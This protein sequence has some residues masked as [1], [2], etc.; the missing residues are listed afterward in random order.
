MRRWVVSFSFLNNCIRV[1][2]TSSMAVV[3]YSSKSD[4]EKFINMTLG[5]WSQSVAYLEMF[6]QSVRNGAAPLQIPSDDIL[7][8]KIFCNLVGDSIVPSR[9]STLCS[10]FQFLLSQDHIS[11]CP[12]ILH[13][14]WWSSAYRTMQQRTEKANKILKMS[15]Q[16]SLSSASYCRLFVEHGILFEEDWNEKWR[17]RQRYAS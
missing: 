16:G 10:I 12:N 3:N 9:V 13:R 5:L 6:L 14:Y 4:Q 11:N 15:W 2:E 1:T 7:T 17:S 8:E